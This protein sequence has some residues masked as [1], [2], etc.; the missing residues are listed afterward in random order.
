MAVS[1]TPADSKLLTH[2]WHSFEGTPKV[3]T[4][5]LAAIGNYKT[6][7]SA[8]ACWHSLRKKL[9]PKQDAEGTEIKLSEK[10][11]DLLSKAWSAM[12][13]VPRVDTKKLAELG[14]YKTA[15]S[16][17]AC[18]HTLRKKLFTGKKDAGDDDATETEPGSEATVA[19]TPKGKKRKA[20]VKDED[21]AEENDKFI[22]ASAAKK[23]AAT[24]KRKTANDTVKEEVVENDDAAKSSV[25]APAP[26]KKGG[27]KPKA[28]A[29]NGT[30][31]EGATDGKTDATADDS[32]T[33]LL[34]GVAA[35][36]KSDS[37]GPKKD[38]DKEAIAGIKDAAVDNE[39]ESA[40]PQSGE[41]EETAGI[42]DAAADKSESAAPKTGG[43]EEATAVVDE[44]KA[45]AEVN[46][47]DAETEI[48]YDEA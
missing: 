44:V 28:A 18:W 22:T 3:D 4:K 17:N 26:T 30:A 37:A 2:V 34:K 31:A 25:P 29:T 10:D 42:K 7:A 5:K 24:K 47:P 45:G 14:G 15:A 19:P 32:I 48:K 13:E 35:D 43:N 12:T 27:R 39:S 8:N 40:A 36:D 11:C 6:A 33:Q 9:L 16:A 21:P 41:E 20:V 23:T 38:G 1:L 46:A